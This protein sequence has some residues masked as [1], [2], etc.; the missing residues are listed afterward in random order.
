MSSAFALRAQIEAAL[1][2]RIPSAL[3]PVPRT[4]RPVAATGIPAVDELLD[5]GLP[6]GAITEIVGA[7]CSGRTSFALSFLAG[8]TQTGKVCAWIDVSDSLDPESVAAASVDMSRLLWVRCGVSSATS[9]RP[10][11][12]RNFS[13]PEKY[14]VPPPIKKGLH[15]GGFGSHP[16]NEVNGLSDAI[17][18][19][20]RPEAFAP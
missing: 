12:Q 20:L 8:M 19:L 11:A 6:L 5:G 17:S 16:R 1:A 10:A 13:L 7:E 15:G 4:I 9:V 18:G 14:L 2:S 3:T